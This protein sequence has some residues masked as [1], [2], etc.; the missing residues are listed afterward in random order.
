M[1]EEYEEV[2]SQEELLWCQQAKCDWIR[3]GDK[4]IKFYQALTKSRIQRN[5]VGAL[6]LERNLW[7]S[8]QDVLK[9]KA[10]EFFQDLYTREVG[11]LPILSTRGMFPTLSTDDKNMLIMPVSKEEVKVA[12]FEIGPLKA[13]GSDGLVPYFFQSQWDIVGDSLW[14]YVSDVFS[15]RVMPE[16]WNT[17]LIALIPKCETQTNF[18]RFRP[19]SQQNERLFI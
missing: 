5:K 10:R 12:L 2:L 1:L 13:P 19:I 18:S 7:C 4:N 3:F 14:K 15:S 17:T 9:S 6:K 16:E 8:D 11:S